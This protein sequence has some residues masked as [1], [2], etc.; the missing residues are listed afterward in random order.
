MVQGVLQSRQEAWRQGSQWLASEVDND[1]LRAIVEAGPHTATEEVAE[2]LS[3]DHSTVIE[4]LKQIKMVKKLAKCVLH[5]CVHAKLLQ[6]YP[7]L[8]DPMDYMDPMEPTG[9]SV[10][11]IFPGKS[12]EWVAIVLAD[13]VQ[14]YYLQPKP[15]K[16]THSLCH[17]KLS[18]RRHLKLSSKSL[19]QSTIFLKN[20][21][22]SCIS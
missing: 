5:V 4:H 15:L 10:H 8:W 7:T 11:G 16:S 3:V 2:E 9:S 17:R 13:N 20:S 1:Q 6:S 18:T 22:C 21:F 19:N 14:I 12:M